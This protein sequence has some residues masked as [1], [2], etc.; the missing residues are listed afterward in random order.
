M[1]FQKNL[2]LADWPARILV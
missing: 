1:I 2:H